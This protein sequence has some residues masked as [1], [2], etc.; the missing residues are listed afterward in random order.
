M[1]V[2]TITR[3]GQGEVRV[4]TG[5]GIIEKIEGDRRNR[6]VKIKATHADLRHPVQGWLDTLA[7]AAWAFAQEAQAR[8]I[9]VD[10]R[11][12]VHR[13]ASVDETIPLDQLANTDKVR[14]L[15]ELTP[16]GATSSDATRSTSPAPAIKCPVEECQLG[17]F[18]SRAELD[19]HVAA[20]HRQPAPVDAEN[21][22]AEADSEPATT[23]PAARGRRGP[24]VEEARPWEAYNTDGSLNL[25]SYAVTASLGY[26]E[27]AYELALAKARTD[28]VLNGGTLVA[29]SWPMVRGLARALLTAADRTQKA[30]RAD[31]HVDRMDASHTRARGAVRAA[32][33]AYPVPW[34]AT[35]EER[36]AWVDQLAD[37]ATNLLRIGVELVDHQ[38]G[39]L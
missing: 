20:D 34:G 5:R 2:E 14:D 25:G 6:L 32:L 31:G 1:A 7:E 29:P 4:E 11:I 38:D 16:V 19:A 13:K 3:P 12:E 10:Y 8:R 27:L 37:V 35:A 17:P 33:D 30:T 15:V 21:P 22:A 24:R 39:R 23:P 26:T 28:L 36:A 18:T 9:E